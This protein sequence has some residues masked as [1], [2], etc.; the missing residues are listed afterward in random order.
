MKDD[1]ILRVPLDRC[2]WRSLVQIAEGTGFAAYSLYGKRPRQ[3]S[4][5]LQNLVNKGLV[6]M[7]Y[8][9]GERGRGGEVMRFRI[10]DFRNKTLRNVSH[11]LDQG[12]VQQISAAPLHE[13]SNQKPSE[14]HRHLATIMFTDL[15]GYTTLAQKDEPLSITLVQESGKL[16]RPIFQKHGGSIVKTIGDAFLVQFLDALSG[17]RCGYDIQRVVR[18]FN[19]PLP[20]EKQLN[21]RIGIHLGDV[22]ESAGDIF[23]D[24]VNIASRIESLADSGGVCL[25]R[26]VYDQVR[27]KIDLTFT[28][29]GEKTLKNVEL[30]MEVFKVD[31]PWAESHQ[32]SKEVDHHRIAVLPFINMSPDP[33]DEYFADGMTEEVISTLSKIRGLEVI[34]RTSVMQY[35]QAPKPVREVCKELTVGTV[36][37]G[38]VRK[39]GN[40]LRISTQM[41]DA[42]RD[43][44][45]W[46]ESYDR[47]L[48]DIFS[49]QIDIA[50]RVADA[51]QARIPKSSYEIGPTESFEAYT[52]YL[53]AMQLFHE[54]TEF[55]LKKAVSLLEEAIHIDGTFARAYVGIANIWLRMANTGY[56]DYATGTRKA[57]IAALKAVELTPGLAEGHAALA[58]AYSSL[59]KGQESISE[60]EK[61]I[62]L[63]PN[64][65]EAHISLGILL[66]VDNPEE[67][68]VAFEKAFRL[69]PLSY[70][71]GDCL[72]QAYTVLD[73]TSEALH[74]LEKLRDTN[75]RYPKIYVRLADCYIDRREFSRAQEMLDLC[76]KIDPKDAEGKIDQGLLYVLTGK[77]EEAKAILQDLM[78]NEAESVRLW[79]QF[80]IQNAL[81]NFDEVFKTLM[82]MGETHDWPFLI[83]HLSDFKELRKDKRF[84]EFCSAVGISQPEQK[85]L[86]E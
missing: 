73:K 11:S 83:K 30:P 25:T 9:E 27:N 60:A 29:L 44:H 53:R 81:G 22:I 7:R 6:E 28:S 49:I 38:S 16:L 13:I 79:A 62:Q 58:E 21:L 31:L 23:G 37:E 70:R 85:S 86:M 67:S 80:W 59:D 51:L 74:V 77:K 68:L 55:S 52:E 33:N 18:E 24:A 12:I 35:K 45:L 78:K 61:A 50:S 84:P 65:S 54:G 47:E 2:G 26:Q 75:P 4:V 63:N 64:L 57:E 48:Q 41:I 32:V 19:I 56:E 10:S 20:L 46:A 66:G 43:R 8:F 40:K 82:R 34:S 71:A 36:L 76:F 14:E 3:V 5:D 15:V 42:S 17:V 72:A 69:D 39:A 1:E